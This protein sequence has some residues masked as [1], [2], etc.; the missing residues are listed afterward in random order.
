V[1]NECSKEEQNLPF[2][3][4][5][6]NQILLHYGE[7]QVFCLIR[8][9]SVSSTK[10]GNLERHSDVLHS[11]KYDTDFPPKSEIHKLKLKELKSKLA[12][13]QQLMAKTKV[14]F[15]NASISSFKVSCLTIKKCKPFTDEESVREYF[16]EIADNLLDRRI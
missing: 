12:A 11:N 15:N 13:Q 8:N 1:E 14:S 5:M 2:S 10:R 6:G 9:A 4:S 16:L 7:R 3:Q